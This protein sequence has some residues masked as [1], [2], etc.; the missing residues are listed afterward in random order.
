M[1][2]SDQRLTAAIITET[3][4]WLNDCV[5]K[6]KHCLGQLT[7][8]QVWWRPDE[9]MNAIGNLILHLYGNVRQWIVS[10]IGGAPDIRDRS[11][12]FSQRQK[13]PKAQLLRR[14][15]EVA[16]AAV[17]VLSTMNAEELLGTR[18]I[19]GFATTGLGANCFRL[20][21]A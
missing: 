2:P 12:E 11:A 20:Q 15:D 9:Q 17:E 7:D 1:Q 6:I 8:D 19:Q 16:A 21:C 13:I 10:G 5:G 3:T 4:Y 14:L 18:H